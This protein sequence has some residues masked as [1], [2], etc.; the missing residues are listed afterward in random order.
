[1]QF[2]SKTPK[3]NGAWELPAHSLVS[4]RINRNGRVFEFLSQDPFGLE[5][6]IND[7]EAMEIQCNTEICRDLSIR[8]H[9]TSTCSFL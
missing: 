6:A 2:M 9:K 5:K 4:L 7:Q 1:M 3:K 8:P